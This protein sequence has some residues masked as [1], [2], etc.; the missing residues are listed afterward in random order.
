MRTKVIHVGKLLREWL[1]GLEWA[2]FVSSIE[3]SLRKK[4]NI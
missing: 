1:H 2:S 3:T 4:T